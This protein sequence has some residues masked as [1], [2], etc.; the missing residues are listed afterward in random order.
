MSRGDLHVWRPPAVVRWSEAVLGALLGLVGVALVVSRPSG[1]VGWLMLLPAAVLLLGTRRSF[2][3]SSD[4]VVAQGRVFRREVALR[5]LR[6]AGVC[7][8]GRPWLQI[9]GGQVTLLR[10]VP[11]VDY[12]RVTPGRRWS[13]SSGRRPPRPGRGSSRR[14]GRRRG[15][16]RRSRRCSGCERCGATLG[17]RPSAC[18]RLASKLAAAF[19]AVGRSDFVRSGSGALRAS[20]LRRSLRWA[21]RTSSDRPV[22]AHAQASMTTGMIIGRRFSSRLTQRPTTRRTV[23]WSW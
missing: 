8:D 1:W 17:L 7:P 15:H 9:Q 21:A 16:R 14:C 3:L 20:S 12:G 18:E 19:A 2:R 6:Q 11:L 13:S 22:L 4:V 5:D 10:M 23:C